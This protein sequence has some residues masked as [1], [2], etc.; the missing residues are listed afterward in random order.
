MLWFLLSCV[1][2]YEEDNNH[3]ALTFEQSYAARYYKFGKPLDSSLKIVTMDSDGTEMGHG[4]GN[5]FKIGKHRFIITAA[6]VIGDELTLLGVDKNDLTPMKVVHIDHENDIAILVPMVPM[7][8]KPI[9]YVVND[10]PSILGLSVVYA[11]YPSDLD[12]SVFHG[13]VSSQTSQDFLMQSFAL[14]GSS[15]SVVFDN[16]GHA[17]GVLSAVKLGYYEF[18]VMPQLHPGLVQVKRLRS[19]SRR[20]IEE[21]IVQWQNS[22]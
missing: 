5:Y 1:I 7:K 13:S 3:R 10:S 18:S 2:G 6:H 16:K 22:N 4:S 11:G 20:R 8:M 17:V 15:G 14:P 12:K 21:I 19:Y 9:N